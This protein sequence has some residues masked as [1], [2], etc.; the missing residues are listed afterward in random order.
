MFLSGMQ[1]AAGTPDLRLKTVGHF[2]EYSSSR[3]A[4]IYNEVAMASLPALLS[5]LPSSLVS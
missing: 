4:G 5:T 2:S 3:K 1:E